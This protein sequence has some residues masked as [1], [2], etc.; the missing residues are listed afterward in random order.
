MI[1]SHKQVPLIFTFQQTFA[2]IIP[3]LAD[4][5]LFIRNN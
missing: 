4:F 1:F 3:T 2:F 5:F